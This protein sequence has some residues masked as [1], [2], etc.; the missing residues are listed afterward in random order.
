MTNRFELFF[1]SATKVT[2]MRMTATLARSA[3]EDEGAI[4]EKMIATFMQAS[5]LGPTTC[6]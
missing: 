4:F 1:F 6:L 5:F 3:D 2:I